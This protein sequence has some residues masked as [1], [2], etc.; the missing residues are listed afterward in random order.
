MKLWTEKGNKMM[1]KNNKNFTSW[2]H[3]NQTVIFNWN[4]VNKYKK[5]NNS[6][7]SITIQNSFIKNGRI[8]PNWQGQVHGTLHRHRWY[9]HHFC[10]LR[11]ALRMDDQ[12]QVR[13]YRNWT[14]IIFPLGSGPDLYWAG[15][16]VAACWDLESFHH[17]Q[18]PG[19]QNAIKELSHLWVYYFLLVSNQHW[20]HLHGELSTYNHGKELQYNVCDFGGSFVLTS[21]QSKE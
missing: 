2:S 9:Q 17:T 11:R 14:I 10:Y 19:C 6:N 15:Y 8:R 5:L 3:R 21:H 7:H 12:T 20:S 18:I 16:C 4:L 1:Y 13:S